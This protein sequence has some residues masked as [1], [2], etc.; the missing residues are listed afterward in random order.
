MKAK[1]YAE[2]FRQTVPNRKAP[3]AEKVGALVDIL[4][5][6][7]TESI[8]IAKKRGVKTDAGLFPCL[9]EVIQKLDSMMSQLEGDY[10]LSELKQ[11]PKEMYLAL[12]EKFFPDIFII[13]EANL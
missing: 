5:K 11:T 13:I 6:M 8:G 12:L 2:L 3:L 1:E 4:F 9:R 10:K 7:N